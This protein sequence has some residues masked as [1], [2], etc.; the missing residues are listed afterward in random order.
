MGMRHQQPK[1]RTGC[2]VAPPPMFLGLW[3]PGLPLIYHRSGHS[4]H[5]ATKTQSHCAGRK[6]PLTGDDSAC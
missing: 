6:A 2:V 3:V 5:G 4:G 1:L